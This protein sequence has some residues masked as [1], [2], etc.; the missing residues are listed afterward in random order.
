MMPG[1]GSRRR[2]ASP[3]S[4]FM[5]AV[6]WLVML[7]FGA[8][9]LWLSVAFAT[10]LWGVWQA[11]RWV[12]VPA[13]LQGWSLESS[14]TMTSRN[15]GGTMQALE[16]RFTYDV[17]GRRFEGTRVGFV[18]LADGL[19]GSWRQGVIA[20][21]REA[22]RGAPLLIHVD[23]EDPARAVV[24]RTLAVPQA[25]FIAAVLAFPCGLVTLL[26]IGLLLQGVGKLAGAALMPLQWPLWALLHGALS[27]PVWALAP[28]DSIEGFAAV[29][30]SVL[31]LLALA[32]GAGLIRALG[33]GL[34]PAPRT[35]PV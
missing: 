3:R 20:R 7:V 19:S 28:P 21:L 13:A 15:V 35:P 6:A 2:A 11:Q 1:M 33:R 25:A 26:L 9:A 12:A 27:L 29:S 32:G 23:P 16:A 10:M 31:A 14:R 4:P 24:E 18:P 22:E 8:A 30:L 34:P 17:A 5:A